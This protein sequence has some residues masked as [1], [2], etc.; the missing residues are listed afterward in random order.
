MAN[1]IETA[2]DLQRIVDEQTAIITEQAKTIRNLGE[3]VKD[4]HARIKILTVLLD[5]HHEL[6]IQH[7]W[8]KPREDRSR[9]N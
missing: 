1:R 2:E 4:M 7:G 5:S 3:L 6:F 9:V 8:A